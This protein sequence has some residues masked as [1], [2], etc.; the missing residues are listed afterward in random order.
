MNSCPRGGQHDGED[1]PPAGDAEGQAGFAQPVRDDEKGL[2][3]RARNDGNHDDR[4]GDGARQP[5]VL[6]HDV[7]DHP[8]PDKDADDDG[9]EA[10][11]QVQ[12]EAH[13]PREGSL[14]VFGEVDG[15]P[16][17]DG[18]TDQASHGQHLQAAE[19][20]G[21]HA[22]AHLPVR[23]GTLREEGEVDRGKP[24]HHHVTQDGEEQAHGHQRAR[25]DEHAR[26]AIRDLAAPK[27]ALTANEKLGSAWCG[28]SHVLH[29]Y[30]A[31]T[32]APPGP[33]ATPHTSRRAMTLIS[34]ATSSS[35]SAT[36]TM[37]LK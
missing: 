13:H 37:A 2:L 15:G 24:A 25:P 14:A 12:D 35:T 3:D 18:D 33:L 32:A 9:G 27:A 17:G 8:G 19:D 26:R 6:P 29:H 31:L 10:G 1:R 22:A 5:V 30:P 7:P 23:Q 34:A 16:Q 21:R 11:Q 36:D 20:G 4:Q 28:R